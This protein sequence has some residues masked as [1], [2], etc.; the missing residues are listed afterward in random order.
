MKP[1]TAKWIIGTITNLCKEEGI[2]KKRLLQEKFVML[3]EV[4]EAI[5]K[6]KQ[7]ERGRILQILSSKKSH[8]PDIATWQAELINKIL[9]NKKKRMKKKQLPYDGEGY[10]TGL[11]DLE[12]LE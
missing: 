11:A 8:N 9:N 6:A 4:N 1:V 5:V 2:D 3:D 7:E 12:E 10:S